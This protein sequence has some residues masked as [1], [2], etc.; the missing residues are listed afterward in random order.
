MRYMVCFFKFIFLK[1]YLKNKI[2]NFLFFMYLFKLFLFKNNNFL[3]FSKIELHLLFL[4]LNKPPKRRNSRGTISGRSRTKMCIYYK[5]ATLTTRSKK[6]RYFKDSKFI[7][8]L[9]ITRLFFMADRTL[10][11]CDCRR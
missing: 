2:G 11:S 8:L 7:A 5:V 10:D 9:D 4:I 3:L 1:K 6:Q